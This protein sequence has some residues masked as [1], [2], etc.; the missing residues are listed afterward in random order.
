MSLSLCPRLCLKRYVLSQGGA[1]RAL[2]MGAVT[3]ANK[4]VAEERMRVADLEDEL[5][6]RASEREA[7]KL[8]MRILEEENQRFRAILASASQAVRQVKAATPT[9]RPT[10]S[11]SR[12]HS[13]HSSKSSLTIPI[14]PHTPDSPWVSPQYQTPTESSPWVGSATHPGKTP[15]AADFAGDKE[16]V[17]PQLVP[18][19]LPPPIDV[20]RWADSPDTPSYAH[21][22]PETAE[23]DEGASY[24]RS[25]T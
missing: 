14:A 3:Q 6:E 5:R 15:T 25:S 22:P 19:S 21:A 1:Y 18:R 16:A 2:R 24:A 4:M 9:R 23:P 7:L 10:P 11:P 12:S 17:Q 20:N 8:A 13:R